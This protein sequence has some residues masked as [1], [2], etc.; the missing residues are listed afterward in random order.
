MNEQMLSV[1]V[2]LASFIALLLLTAVLDWLRRR[3]KVQ[4]SAEFEAAL[5]TTVRAGIRRAEEWAAAVGKAGSA[6]SSGDKARVAVDLV[7]SRW[8]KVSEQQARAYVDAEIA[9]MPGVGATGGRVIGKQRRRR[10]RQ[11]RMA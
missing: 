9:T 10:R 11:S 4:V 6:V 2:D 8:P 7:R 5:R 3:F 1:A